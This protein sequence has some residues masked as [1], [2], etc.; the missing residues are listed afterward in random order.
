[1]SSFFRL[2]LRLG[3]AA[4][5][6]G[7]AAPV[8]AGEWS[9]FTAGTLDGFAFTHAHLPDGRFVFGTGGAVWVQDAFGAGNFTTVANGAGQSFDPSFVAVRSASEALIGG[10]GFFGPSGLYPFDPSAPATDIGAALATLQN[11][12]GVYWRH[13][14]SGREGWL[15]AGNNGSS[16]KNNLVYVSADGTRAGAVTGDLS[17]FSGGL[18]TDA[19]GDVYVALAD[20]DPAVDNQVLKLSAAQVDAAV[21]A[22]RNGAP[23]PVPKSAATA[24]VQ[25][26][27]SGGLAVDGQGRVWVGG[28]QIDYLQAFDPVTGVTRRFFPDHAPIQGA[29]GPPSYTPKKFSMNG[30]DFLSFLA[31]DSAYASGSDLVLGYKA[32]AELKVRSVEFLTTSAA[33]RED[34]GQISVTVNLS[35]PAVNPV[36]VP[37]Q[38]SGSATSGDDFEID[39]GEI[40]FGVGESQRVITIDLIN[41]KV[42]H[43]SA[44]TIVLA[45]GGPDPV[46]EAG[47][48]APGTETFTLELGDDDTPPVIDLSQMLGPG[49][50]G[51]AYTHAVAVSGGGDPTRW[52][53]RGLPPGLRIDPRTGEIEGIPRKSGIYDRVVIVAANRYGQ[54][55]SEP[56]TLQVETLPESVVGNFSGLVDR[57]APETA[58]LGAR[59]DLT[60]Q[61]SGAW[62]GRVQ[63]GRRGRGIR[64][65]IDATGANPVLTANFPHLG[66]TVTLTATLDTATGE[67]TGGF[68]GGGTLNGWRTVDESA[69]TGRDHF[70]L[71]VPGGPAPEVPEGTGFGVARFG[72]HATVRF[73]G[74]LGDGSRFSSG[75]KLGPL[76][77]AV[78]YR[79]LHRPEGTLMGSV[80]I[81]EAIGQEITGDLSWSKPPRTRGRLYPNGWDSPLPLGLAGGKY[82]P[83]DAVTLPLGTS[84]MADPNARLT[85]QDG[86]I[87]TLVAN[88]AIFGARFLSRR[89]VV[90]ERPQRMV[91]DNSTGMFRAYLRLDPGPDGANRRVTALGLLIP[92]PATPDPY[93]ATGHG[94][95]LFNIDR[96]ETRSGLA[97]L[98]ALP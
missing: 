7:S 5:M 19:S 81:S 37:V 40:T 66:Q 49:K 4:A 27:A 21:E 89:R 60:V 50:I 59:V 34:A 44:E 10:G 87:D 57:A 32:V 88:P 35:P 97:L 45:L 95:F 91:F 67:M 90:M 83:V 22:V 9:V 69:R 46:A 92:N 70:L 41:D 62:S 2:S 24:L 98:E 80:S 28:Y 63:I 64:G 29:S 48:G 78:I 6:V 14:T 47:L 42:A 86:G 79:S 76:G 68:A 17:Q 53:A 43:E 56:F 30:D 51:A 11:Y 23:N 18:D 33:A 20:L 71:A 54:S 82:E 93:D 65:T 31:N 38:I 96:T 1:M 52:S 55:V 15:I 75:G 73:T 84:A 12:T 16:G 13:P 25:A 61:P 36:T 74:R 8:S 72:R 77:E 39:S 85:L 3:L 26:A 58:G 94:F